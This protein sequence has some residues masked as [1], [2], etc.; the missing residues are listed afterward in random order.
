MALVR[1]ASASEPPDTVRR[2]VPAPAATSQELIADYTK[3]LVEE[4]PERPQ[5]SPKHAQRLPKVCPKAPKVSPKSP[6]SFRKPP[7]RPPQITPDYPRA[8]PE[9]GGILVGSRS[10]VHSSIVF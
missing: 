1:C 5:S 6:R 8:S 2:A 4:L 10:E 7:Q 9:P 3:D